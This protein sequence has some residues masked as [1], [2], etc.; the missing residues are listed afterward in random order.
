MI[1]VNQL[2][3]AKGVIKREV[4]AKDAV[5]ILV[6][7]PDPSIGYSGGTSKSVPPVKVKPAGKITSNA[8]HV[9]TLGTLKKKGGASFVGGF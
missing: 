9:A 4:A 3:L 1:I 7:Q 6:E 2:R 8:K 5:P